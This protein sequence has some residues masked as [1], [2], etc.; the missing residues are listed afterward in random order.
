[1]SQIIVLGATGFT[2]RMTAEVLLRRGVAPVLAGRDQARLGALAAE[3]GGGLKTARVS[4]EDPATITAVLEKGGV[5]VTTVGPFS[6]FGDAAAEAAISAGAHYIDSAGEPGFNRRI[7]DHYG[8]QAEAAG[9]V[10]LPAFAPEWVL[11]SVAGA[12]ALAK[13]GVDS[14]RVDTGYFLVDA[15]T[16]KP[17]GLIPLLRMFSAASLASGSGLFGDKGFAWTDGALVS[18]R[19]GKSRRT[20]DLS[21]QRITGLSTGGS[22][23]LTLPQAFPSVRD[24]NVYLGWFNRVSPLLQ[25]ASAIAGPALRW[26]LLRRGLDRVV[27]GM[28][29]WRGAPSRSEIGR[30][31]SLTAATA[32]DEAG[33]ELAR[34]Q[35]HG[36]H[37]YPLT[38][39]LLAWGAIKLSEG[40]VASI[41]ALGP[42]QAFGLDELCDGCREAGLRTGS[43]QRQ[44]PAA[45]R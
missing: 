33:S 43:E 39:E 38:A 2:G 27:G 31:R 24:V 34:I 42:L 44:L 4:V 21:D 8:P 12:L 32:H 6:R 13:A 7:F 26:P 15:S 23:H 9:V 22:E 1:M 20:F 35:L 11:G 5:L 10:M 40:A 36:P 37:P 30:I 19:W 28:T 45:A 3:L 16:G 41:G 18:E 14:V 17:L 29:R 25:V